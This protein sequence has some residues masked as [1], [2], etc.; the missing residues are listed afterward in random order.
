MPAPSANWQY[1]FTVIKADLAPFTRTLHSILLPATPL[2]VPDQPCPMKNNMQQ[3]LAA[4]PKLAGI[5]LHAPSSSSST[6]LIHWLRVALRTVDLLSQPTRLCCFLFTVSLRDDTEHLSNQLS[7][8]LV[9]HFHSRREWT[10]RCGAS[11]SS[12]FGDPVFAA[13]W[14][15]LG[16]RDEAGTRHPTFSPT[17]RVA[18]TLSQSIDVA[19]ICRSAQAFTFSCG[20]AHV[21]TATTTIRN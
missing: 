17:A 14:I 12:F 15:A 2:L 1:P 5:D 6:L 13:K 10:V 11:S 4:S 9:N 20:S 19:I 3:F 18:S 7:S 8:A 16:Y 21:E